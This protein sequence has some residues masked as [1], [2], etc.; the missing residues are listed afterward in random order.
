MAKLSD[1]QK[2]E[3]VSQYKNGKSILSLSKELGIHFSS[4]LSI[5][6]VRNITRRGSKKYSFNE[7]YFQKIDTEEKAYWLGFIYAEGNIYRSTF[8]LKL[9]YEDLEHLELFRKHIDSNHPIKKVKGLVND[10]FVLKISSVLLKKQLEKLGVFPN[11]SATIR[12]PDWLREDLKIHFIRGFFDG[13]G[14]VSLYI[15]KGCKKHRI[16]IGISSCSQKFLEYI[17]D[18]F[19]DLFKEKTGSLFQRKKI[20]NRNY[21]FQLSYGTIG[22][23]KIAKLLYENSYIF[24]IRKKQGCREIL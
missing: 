15:P 4:V 9:G 23:K 10:A 21:S 1:L 3:V 13:D 8:S 19:D 7:D 11:K 2:I 20:D 22:T 6:K 24:M 12:F 14:W 18:F 17:K 16:T 5:L